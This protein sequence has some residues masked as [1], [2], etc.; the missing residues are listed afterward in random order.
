VFGITPQTTQHIIRRGCRSRWLCLPL[1]GSQSRRRLR[2]TAWDAFPWIVGIE[3]EEG[4]RALA[5]KVL[6]FALWE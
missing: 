4:L 3:Q 2:G 5:I 6:L 1:W